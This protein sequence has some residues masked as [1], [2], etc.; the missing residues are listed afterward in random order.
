MVQPLIAPTRASSSAVCS[1]RA[2][3]DTSFDT[4]NHS[5]SS[6][7]PPIEPLSLLLA[8]VTV[9][10]IACMQRASSTSEEV[11]PMLLPTARSHSE[12]F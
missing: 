3:S 5:S 12:A 8:E 9:I 2:I 10:E 4:D 7:S 11:A 1:L 6:S